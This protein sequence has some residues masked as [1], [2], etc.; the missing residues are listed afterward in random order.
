MKI[1]ENT[2]FLFYVAEYG[3]FN[4]EIEITTTDFADKYNTSQQTASRKLIELEK[5]GYIKRIKT[6]KGSIIILTNTG[7]N[8]LENIADRL[9][10]IIKKVPKKLEIRGILETGMG[11]GKFYV[12]IP[13]YNN[14]FKDYLKFEDIFPGTLN[15]RLIEEK[16][17]ET[18]KILRTEK[19]PCIKIQGWKNS[20]RTYGD[21][22][23]Y[24]AL[25]NDKAEGAALIID[26]TS[27]PNEILELISPFN[28]REKLNLNDGD[29]IKVTIFFN[30][31]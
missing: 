12:N 7:R 9:N 22:T 11:E 3:A 26:R 20:D 1:D 23:C 10:L 25:I 4:E 19:Y 13:G 21:V 14:Q 31:N 2:E 17:I 28:L 5:K 27:H 15:L 16:D 29:E 6:Q 30:E 18:R 8:I 24:K